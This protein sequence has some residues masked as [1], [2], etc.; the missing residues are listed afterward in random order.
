MNTSGRVLI[1]DS[2]KSTLIATTELLQSAGYQ[3]I[4]VH[5]GFEAMQALESS[6]FDLL[7]TEIHMPGNENLELIQFVS[8]S[9]R[10]MPVI[11]Y[12]ANP[13]LD[14][15]IA[16]IQLPVMSYL[17]KPISSD[18]LIEQVN[19]SIASYIRLK[20]YKDLEEGFQGYLEEI[21]RIQGVFDSSLQET[22]EVLESTRRSFKSKQLA[23]LRRKLEWILSNERTR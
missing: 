20:G 22:I 10:G 5:D 17:I 14:T 2:N 1:A 11:I 21:N 8:R 4:P 9:A 19:K 12:T 23:A 3:V 18:T 6:P 7:I 16:S 13:S 15:A